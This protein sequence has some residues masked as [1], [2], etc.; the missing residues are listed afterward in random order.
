[1]SSLIPN[2][3][4]LLTPILALP[5][6]PGTDASTPL[7]HMAMQL[8]LHGEYSG[9][10]LLRAC[11]HRIAV[12]SS[13]GFDAIASESSYPGPA[14]SWG[15]LNWFVETTPVVA[16]NQAPSAGPKSNRQ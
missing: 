4:Q 3:S 15:L 8:L 6:N 16:V 5:G 12:W 9:C 7:R 11:H 13:R 10:T 1:M 2:Q 14:A